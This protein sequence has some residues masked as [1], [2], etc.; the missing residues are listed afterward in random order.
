MEIASR[1]SQVV[2]YLKSICC[3]GVVSIHTLSDR[4]MVNGQNLLVESADWPVFLQIMHL[5]QAVVVPSFFF[6]SGFLF[7][8]NFK[9]MSW[10]FFLTKGRKRVRSLLVPYIVGNIVLL[11]VLYVAKRVTG[12]TVATQ[13]VNLSLRGWAFFRAVFWCPLAN[14]V[15]WFLRDL[16]LVMLVSPILCSL[17]LRL[18]RV[19]L[20]VLGFLWLSTLWPSGF[21]GFSAASFFFFT[22]GAAFSLSGIDFVEFFAE[23]RIGRWCTICYLLLFPIAF[24]TDNAVVLNALIFFSMPVLV[25]MVASVSRPADAKPVIGAAAAFFIYAYHHYPQIAV[26]TALCL[27]IKPEHAVWNYVIFFATVA[28][29]CILLGLLYRVLARCFRKWVWIFVGR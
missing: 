1:S 12:G 14:P 10:D 16:M 4:V 21:A 15:F 5:L 13:S 6:L 24:Y 8:L 7:F 9:E 22:A 11:V 26:K 20:A 3:I 28:L 27:W 25:R 2:N 19:T 29:V 18:K 23:K 17:L